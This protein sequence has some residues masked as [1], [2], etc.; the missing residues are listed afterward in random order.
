MEPVW[1]GQLTCDY[2]HTRP[3]STLLEL[4]LYTASL[5]R[6][7]LIFMDDPRPYGRVR[8]PGIVDI[9]EPDHLVLTRRWHDLLADPAYA[10]AMVAAAE[11]R[12]LL[13]DTAL[14]ATE[15]ELDRGGAAELP[16]ARATEAFLGVMSAHIVNWLL[17]DD[18]WQQLLA[19]LLGGAADGRACRL[20]LNTPDAT[21]HL[22]DAHLV[23][24]DG[25]DTLT[26]GADLTA[27]A[28]ALAARAGTL[29]GDGSPAAAAMPLED[30]NR[31]AAL[32]TAT[33]ITDTGSQRA[34]IDD[35]RRRAVGLRDAWVLAARLAAAGDPV[36]TARVAALTAVC[37]WA[38][39]SEESRKVQRH[40]YLA[41]ARRWCEYHGAD[42]ATVTT[43][44]LLTR[45]VTR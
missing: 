45:G 27:A 39:D 23:L 4:D 43:A 36:A 22:L 21:G 6:W 20:A 29:Y 25:A 30:R 40:R 12:K 14:H 24:L 38:A 2:E 42:P 31:A 10:S 13:A 1:K 16:L 7:P 28:D 11:Q 15:H 41:A 17:P 19:G 44:D 3:G 8:R 32:L 9:P 35:A 18:Q 37:R 26:G 5:L 33:A 34:V